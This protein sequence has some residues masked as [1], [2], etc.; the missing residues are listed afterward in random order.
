[1]SPSVRA[2][3]L[4]LGVRDEDNS[5]RLQFSILT[6]LTDGE[7]L[8]TN[9]FVKLFTEDEIGNF[10]VKKQGET[11]VLEFVPFDAR[12]NQYS[13]NFISYDTKQT[14]FDSDSFIFGNTVS[15]ASTNIVSSGVN[16]VFTISPDITSGKLLLE[17]TSQDEQNYEYNEINFVSE[18]SNV[19]LSE[20]G[21]ITISDESPTGIG[22]YGITPSGDVIFTPGIST[23]FK[24]NVIGVSIAS[25]EFN[26]VAKQNLRYANVESLRVSIGASTNP[27]PVS[28]SQFT[29]TFKSAYYIIQTV[30]FNTV[31][32]EKST[33]L[34]EITTLNNDFNAIIS[35]YGDVNVDNE[36]GTFDANSSIL[37][38]LFFTPVPDTNIEMTILRHIVTF[39]DFVTFPASINFNNA[40]LTTGVTIL[41]QSSDVAFKKD[42]DLKHKEFP[43]FERRFN[44]SLDIETNS[45][46][47]DLED[48][49]IYLP[50]HYFVSGEKVS[51]RSQGAEFLRI[52]DTVASET[53]TVGTSTVFVDSTFS[54]SI[55]DFF[56]SP[57]TG[58]ISCVGVGT[59]SVSL[60]AELTN[61]VNVGAAVSFF[62]LNQGVFNDTTL[63]SIGIAQTFISGVGNTDKLSGDLYI[64]KKNDLYI[65]FGTSPIDVIKGIPK[66]IDLTSVGS[67]DNHYITSNN[68]NSRCLLSI[69]NM[70]QSPIVSTSTTSSVT[71]NVSIVETTVLVSSIE[72]FASGDLIKVDDEIMKITSTGIGTTALE[73]SVDRPFMGSSLQEHGTGSLITKLRG[74][75]NIVGSKV[76]FASAPYGPIFD[77]IRGDVNI[78]ST[79]Q[80]RAFLRSATP[81]D[82]ERT[83]QENYV[84]D[85]LQDEFNSKQKNFTLLSN[86]QPVTGIA[87]LKSISLINGLFQNPGEDYDFE[88][89]F[90]NTQIQ[91]T[92][93]AT[94]ALYDPNN[95]SVPRGGIP[96]SLGSTPGFGYQ[97]LIS[98]GGTAVVSSAG[99]IQSISIGY[100][101][102]GYREGI[103][104]IVKV[105][106][107]TESVGT[108]N[109]EFIGTASVS[110]GS[111]VSIAIT[112][113]GTGYTTSNPPKV[114][115]DEPFSYE[116]LDLLYQ[117]PT[118][119]LGTEAK[120]D[121]VVGQGS[122]IIDFNIR[123]FGYS[124]RV[125]D[126]LTVQAGGPTGIPTISSAP[127]ENF[128]IIVDTI[129]NDEYSGWTVGEL[130]KL[131]DLDS[132]FNGS[133]RIFPISINQN[134][135]AILAKEGSLIE[136][137]AVL[138]IFINDVLQEP[139]V[140]YKFEG[141]SLIEFTEA[142]RSG[143]K[144]RI[145]FYKGTPNVD[146][147]AVDILETVQTGDTL[148][149]IDN[150]GI[151]TQEKRLVKDIFLP[152]TVKTNNYNTVGVSS[153]N[154]LLR[155]V[156]WCKMRDDS[157]V[158]GVAISKSRISYEPNIY[159]LT[160][161]IKT[162]SA[163]STQIY[164][165]NVITM[166][167]Q[168]NE[169]VD[170]DYIN[171]IQLIDDNFELVGAEGTAI[172]NSNGELIAIQLSTGGKGYSEVPDVK[173]GDPVYS[174]GERAEVTA[175]IAGDAVVSF[176]LQ[177][178]GSGYTNSNPPPVL[179]GPPTPK[180]D[181]LENVEYFGDFGFITGVNVGSSSTEV[182]FDLYI[183]EDSFL[184]DFTFTNPIIEESKI[185]EQDYFRVSNSPPISGSPLVST[186]SDGNIIGIASDTSTG[187]DSVYQVGS[188]S[189]VSADAYGVGPVALTRVLVYVAD[190]SNISTGSS[191]Y[192]GDFS[193]GRIKI[194]ENSPITN[195]YVIQPDE[196][197]S[198]LNTAPSVRRFNPLKYD[199][200]L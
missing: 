54:V 185:E 122:S 178:V 139:N 113:P 64:Y 77:P 11:A 99:T 163:G 135:F 116:N 19:Y 182:F 121:I 58:R 16:T 200:Y 172:I 86:E 119:G 22:T 174:G 120:I 92:G 18:N 124:F 197:V 111:I 20:F 176:T 159:P 106:V 94:S 110:N 75:Y 24:T 153:N 78:R 146:V 56:E 32:Q 63:N 35:Q 144:C 59:T 36:L 45:V 118:S 131:D 166:F 49:L 67:G 37:S 171:S 134:R 192:F 10:D 157:F 27:E 126:I 60:S 123:N 158:D 41:N 2:K 3:K 25:T 13:F 149:I 152:D 161:I 156:T 87:T 143:T 43:I 30:G 170:P 160:N 107:Q 164:V 189:A 82:N 136:L 103:Q 150:D 95:A 84:L 141:G 133:E 142:P 83:Y 180:Y 137:S 98:A 40:E 89:G 198:G 79:F 151:L 195:N 130:E 125:G 96:V 154:E 190:N 70:I 57:G 117:S 181:T 31:T 8:F 15:I 147:V 101:G 73:F 193:W 175:N 194:S 14:I 115:F 128:S 65:G 33:Q 47:V 48:D 39:S 5:D 102:S 21:R 9:Q 50:N 53:A 114:V 196:I 42:F 44:G 109:I 71:S 199:S 28:V 187:I 88:E 66:L 26:V 76:Y 183:P 173:I 81:F 91:F 69:D 72:N 93:T 23:T 167:N 177:N 12:I 188:V 68:P 168:N 162:V 140:A 100:S 55:G 38:E 132:L 34:T 186:G 191:S 145:Y 97:P 108:P 138:L 1:M 129:R 4:F 80:G 85:D 127:F 90:G 51:Y 104:T 165:D 62:R 148:Q 6:T 52:L 112:N 29:S 184:R 61:T 46:G 169:N 105:G 155:S 17:T 74:N 179:I 7:K